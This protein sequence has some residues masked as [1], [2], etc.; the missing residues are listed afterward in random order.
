MTFELGTSLLD[1]LPDAV[2]ALAPDGR[3]LWWNATA[4]DM[5]G[6]AC[7]EATGRTIFDLIVP[8]DGV[9][10]E[11]QALDSAAAGAQVVYE[12]VRRRRDGVLMHVSICT[13][14]ARG[15]DGAAT[16]LLTSQKDVTRLKVARNAKLL[17]SRFGD[18]VESM[19]DAMVIVDVSA[20]IVLVNA[21]AER[22]FGYQRN[23]LIGHT[24][25]VLVPERDRAGRLADRNLALAHAGGPSV[26]DG[27]QLH[28]LRKDGAEFPIE[29]TSCPLQTEEGPMVMNALRDLTA[30]RKAEQK[31]RDLLE[32]APD[33]MVIAD[34]KGIIVLVNT[35]AESLFGYKRDELLGK[36]IEI[37]VPARSR[38]AHVGFRDRYFEHPRPRAMGVGLDLHGRRKDGTE[39]PVEV[40]LSPLDTEDGPLIS[41]AIR[42][43]TERRKVEQRLQA[44]NRTKSE[45]LANMSH[46]LR[47]P[48]NGI[49]GFSEFLHDERPGPLNGKQKEYLN[50][51]LMSGRHLLQLIN[52]IL[53][54]SKVEAGR[55]EFFPERFDVAEVVEEARVALSPQAEAAGIRIDTVSSAQHAPVELDR[56]KLKQV[57]LNLLSNAV[58]FTPAGGRV[59]VGH[60]IA[61]DGMLELWVEDSG[62]GIQPEDL[63]KLFVEFQQLDSGTSR[64]YGGTGLGLALVKRIVEL[65]GGRIAV[66]SEPGR[67]SVF[68][69]RLPSESA[70]ADAPRVEAGP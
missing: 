12:S 55:M 53:D 44:A 24:V 59:E 11:R 54:L 63:G 51:I 39:F 5:F 69:V 56:Q 70:K 32:S 43:V 27:A 19:P 49:I 66:R 28:G 15:S 68:T 48:L 14:R 35:Q 20:R 64:R 37:L 9:D 30:R 7:D 62:I 3:V 29:I 33:A 31:F 38:A 21:H 8:P 46:E 52:D 2:A 40:S 60:G 47:T 67:G 45:F 42:D 16:Y 36:G 4:A 61:A 6:Y 18:L 13:R 58:K 25:E 50:D 34:A 10:E 22:L 17:D 57:L 26:H 65:Q 23:E 1:S 41:S